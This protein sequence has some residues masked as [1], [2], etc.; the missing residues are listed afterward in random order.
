MQPLRETINRDSIAPRTLAEVV[1]HFRRG[2]GQKGIPN[3][4]DLCRLSAKL[5]CT[6]MGETRLTDVRAVAVWLH[7]LLLAPGSKAK[8]RNIM[9]VLFSHAMRYEW[10]DR[11][12]IRL[13][14]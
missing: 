1:N 11:N 6:D 12:P 13:V 8:I 5:D 10:T 7:S 2:V 9:S 14:R 3:S 4:H